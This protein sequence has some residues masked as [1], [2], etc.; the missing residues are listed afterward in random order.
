MDTDYINN[1]DINCTDYKNCPKKLQFTKKK[2]KTDILSVLMVGCWGVYCWDGE[3]EIEIYDPKEK[4]IITETEIYGGKSVSKGIVN[5]TKKENI[6]AVFLA[7]DNLYNFDKPKK[8]L[9]DFIK[10]GKYPSKK[11]YKNNHLLSGQ[12]IEVQIDEGFIKCFKDANVKDFYIAVGNHDIQNCFDLNFQLNFSKNKPEYKYNLPAVYYN[13]VYQMM[14]YNVNFI[15]ID[16]NMYEDDANT[17]NNTYYTCQMIEEQRKWIIKTL[18][19]ERC[20]W[21]II[22]GHIPY[23][24]NGHKAKKPYIKNRQ[25]DILFDSISNCID[26]PKVQIYM[27]ADEHNQ[28]FL[29]DNKHKMGLVVAGSGGTPLDLKI[30]K[31]KFIEGNDTI[32]K[33]SKPY[34]GFTKFEFSGEKL[35][36]SYIVTD[37]KNRLEHT[38]N[39][40]IASNFSFNVK[41]QIMNEYVNKD[42]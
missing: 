20:R 15:V 8:M 38:D 42:I 33:Y 37:I 7:G 27:C 28:Q 32:T 1:M 5:F 39:P 19:R 36:V 16:T 29:Y 23:K 35:D 40:L 17:C 21:N 22:V 10:Q 3:K 11:E 4:K 25:L 12:N 26:C 2:K 13:V 41:G 6:D 24:A 31:E 18:K 30:I 9:L 14:G 34:F